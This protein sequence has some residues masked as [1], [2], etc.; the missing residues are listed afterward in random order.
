MD[1][2]SR[3]SF[4][5]PSYTAGINSVYRRTSS[6]WEGRFKSSLAVSEQ[7]VLACYRYIELNPVRAGM[8]CH[9]SDYRWSS[10]RHHAAGLS[11]YP[12]LPHSEWLALGVDRAMRHK[13]YAELVDDGMT[14]EEL[15]T[16]RRCAR[17]GLPTGS[18][19]FNSE[20]EQALARRL[21]DGRRGRPK[22]GL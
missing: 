7:Y 6:L 19:R 20:I 2:R 5:L 4:L 14:G 1:R 11:E 9:P 16:F 17:K 10:Y 22:K 8:V 3:I 13:R 12:I 18:V 21:G 15:E